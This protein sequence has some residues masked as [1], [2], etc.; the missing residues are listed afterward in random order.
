MAQLKWKMAQFK[1]YL[2]KA[3]FST[4]INNKWHSQ[5]ELQIKRQ[6]AYLWKND[7]GELFNIVNVE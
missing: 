1:F 3:M 5:K 6:A 7:V 4:N 2:A